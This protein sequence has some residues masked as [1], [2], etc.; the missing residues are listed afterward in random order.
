MPK[1]MQISN[2]NL[3]NNTLFDFG[4]SI[5]E[6][7]RAYEGKIFCLN[8]HLKRLE[9]S[10]KAVN[11]KLPCSREKIKEKIL[12]ELK[13]SK[14]KEAYVRVSVNHKARLNIVVKPVKIYPEEFYREGVRIVTAAIKKDSVHAVFPS[15]KTANFLN[16]ILAR[17]EASLREDYYHRQKEKNFYLIKTNM[18]V[19]LKHCC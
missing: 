13:G 4:Q 10:A 14:I 15:A 8:E 12:K 7:M 9:E 3:L 16:G 19:F 17:I 5:F 6:S 2:C 1:R 11:I 18:L